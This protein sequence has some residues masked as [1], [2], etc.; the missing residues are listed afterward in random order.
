MNINI[1]ATNI[2]LAPAEADYLQKKINMLDRL[3]DPNDTSVS[4]DVEVGKTTRHH[5]SGEI[6][7]TEINLRKDGKQ[8]RAVA[9]EATI[10]AA[11]DEAKD[12]MMRVL[13]QNKSR[14]QTL[15]RRGGATIKNI[16]K[17]IGGGIG[18]GYDATAR[19]LRKLSWRKRR[20]D[21]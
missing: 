7:R 3:I 21:N 17:G 2:T 5:K 6:F 12:E 1:K 20:R 9:E 18:S 11:I 16:L 19:T 15:I 8:F 13:S 10:L 14:E 4:C